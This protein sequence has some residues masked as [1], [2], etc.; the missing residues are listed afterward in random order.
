MLYDTTT[1]DKA[2][3]YSLSIFC[4][5]RYPGFKE[6]CPAALSKCLTPCLNRMSES[7]GDPSPTND[8]TPFRCRSVIGLSIAGEKWNDKSPQQAGLE[9]ASLAR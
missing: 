2:F 1:N 6:G 4:R 9:S 7:G 5:L 3:T 8:L